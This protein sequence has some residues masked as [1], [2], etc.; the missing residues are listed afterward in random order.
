M[1]P[2]LIVLRQLHKFPQIERIYL[3]GSRA[4]GDAGP[5]SD[6][7][8]AIACPQAGP[9]IWADIREAIDVADTL[10]KI[11]TVRLEEAAPE[12]VKRIMAEGR[13][14]YERG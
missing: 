14:L 11:D 1:A 9:I 8:L 13:L 4:R 7:D 5:R 3:F 6:I 12:L 2:A 10:L